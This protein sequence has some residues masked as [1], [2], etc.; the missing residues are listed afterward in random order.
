MSTREKHMMFG[1]YHLV[2]SL[3]GRLIKERASQ[4]TGVHPF[5]AWFHNFD[6]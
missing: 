5:T 2:I 3:A 4:L 1:F 6:W